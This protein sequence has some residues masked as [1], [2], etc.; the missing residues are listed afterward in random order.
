M[1]LV[2]ISFCDIDECFLLASVCVPGKQILTMNRR[3]EWSIVG[4]GTIDSA[5]RQFVVRDSGNCSIGCRKIFET[6]VSIRIS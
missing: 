5:S 3:A 4:V 6:G 2:I 1:S